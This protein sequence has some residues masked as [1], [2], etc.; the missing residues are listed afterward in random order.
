MWVARS[1]LPED[2]W[3]TSELLPSQRLFLCLCLLAFLPCVL[4]VRLDQAKPSCSPGKGLGS[5]RRGGGGSISHPKASTLQAHVK[6]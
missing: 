1:L 2:S 4:L 5:G 3:L 6:V